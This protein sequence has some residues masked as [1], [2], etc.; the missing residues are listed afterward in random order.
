M[1]SPVSHMFKIGQ[2]I[3]KKDAPNAPSYRFTFDETLTLSKTICQ[4]LFLNFKSH[5]F[6]WSL[7]M[8][9]F[10]TLI[11]KG[12]QVLN[13]HTI[14]AR[15]VWVSQA[16]IQQ[17][18]PSSSPL[19]GPSIHISVRTCHNYLVLLIAQ[20]TS[21]CDKGRPLLPLKSEL[22]QSPPPICNLRVLSNGHLRGM[23]PSIVQ[24]SKQGVLCADG[25][26]L[27]MCH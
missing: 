9:R 22:S 18:R 11:L 6:L 1:V 3:L 13:S 17:C 10:Q 26:G 8:F 16:S 12:R 14:F 5:E 7:K 27:S 4:F 19:H 21:W 20:F 23:L 15:Q 24:R 2:S 25:G